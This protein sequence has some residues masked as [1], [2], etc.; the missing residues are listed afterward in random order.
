MWLYVR[1]SGH[2]GHRGFE[3]IAPSE[4]EQWIEGMCSALPVEAV[5]STVF[6][7]PAWAA[8]GLPPPARQLGR[9]PLQPLAQTLKRS[10]EA[11]VWFRMCRFG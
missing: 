8:A 7:C 10:L 2:C 4:G 6:Q 1:R 5:S 3:M 9:K 11:S